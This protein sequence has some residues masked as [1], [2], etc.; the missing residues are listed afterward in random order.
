MK[1][2][3]ALP[4]T[5]AL[6][7]AAACVLRLLQNHTGYEADTGLPIP[8]NFA[9]LALAVLLAGLA[10][11]LALTAR[12]LP[13]EED[14]GPVLPRDFS[15]E[16]AGLLTLPMGGVFLLALSGLSDL[17][18]GLRLLPEGLVSSRHAIYGILRA[19]GLGF[20]PQGQLLMG[21]LT[22]AAAVSL[23]PVLAGCRR[24]E[25]GPRHKAPS[26]ITLLPVAALVV[27]LV[28]TYRVDSVNPSLTMYY[29]ELLALVFM[30]LGFYR[31]SSFAFQAGRT[32]RFG[33]YAA[34]SLVLCAASLADGSAY[35]STLLLYA[36]GALTLTGF[37]LLRIADSLEAERDDGTI[38]GPAG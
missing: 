13:S 24:R 17:A 18:E 4:L 5:A 26:A 21:G 30:T 19:G 9:A 32:R 1:K 29:V 34:A 22:L 16:N 31:L 20:T 2:E 33:L 38:I 37:L 10:A 35:L 28:L 36:G 7:G 25:G 8:G 3:Y 27:R 23:F 15:T 6:G 14:P 12:F 11:A